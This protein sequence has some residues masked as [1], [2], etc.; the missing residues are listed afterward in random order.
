[1]AAEQTRTA[2]TVPGL[3]AEAAP[4]VWFI[5]D[6]IHGADDP[7]WQEIRLALATAPSLRLIVSS[8][9]PPGSGPV[10]AL[11]PRILDE[12]DLAFDPDETAVL[13]RR[14]LTG[15]NPDLTVIP[16]TMAGC[17]SLV[18]RYLEQVRADA[19]GGVWT[20]PPTARNWRCC[21]C[22]A[23]PTQRN[24]RVT[25]VSAPGCSQRGGC[26]P[27]PGISCGVSGA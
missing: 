17:P 5:D 27:S 9:D 23:P 10:G 22:G 12:R 18:H 21:R 3:S 20:V 26:G 13:A 14:L 11:A 6:L 1:M 24:R 8:E 7:L 25:V 4:A 2:P 16:E 19:A 15:P